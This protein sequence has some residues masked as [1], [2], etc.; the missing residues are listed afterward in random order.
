MNQVVKPIL[1]FNSRVGGSE[2]Q[3]K[4][5]ANRPNL[6]KCSAPQPT[7]ITSSASTKTSIRVTVVKLAK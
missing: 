4:L 7:S 2:W 5:T 3:G 6:A 1:V